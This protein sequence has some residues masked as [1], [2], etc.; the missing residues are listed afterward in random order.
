M[1]IAAWRAIVMPTSLPCAQL[2]TVRELNTGVRLRQAVRLLASGAS[3]VCLAQ[4]RPLHICVGCHPV[5]SVVCL[6]KHRAVETTVMKGMGSYGLSGPTRKTEEASQTISEIARELKRAASELYFADPRMRLTET[7][8]ETTR[9]AGFRSSG[10]QVV[11]LA[12]LSFTNCDI[13]IAISGRWVTF[14]GADRTPERLGKG[15]GFAAIAAS[16]PNCREGRAPNT[17]SVV[18][19]VPER[20]LF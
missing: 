6:V 4:L 11:T 12:H 20:P 8:R 3:L 18:G 19:D 15:G 7:I 13:S 2:F 5:V 1:A 9:P 16:V 10:T 14:A 17:I